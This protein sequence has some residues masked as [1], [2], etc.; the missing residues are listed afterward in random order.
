MARAAKRCLR[1]QARLNVSFR[2]LVRG[3]ENE[4]PIPDRA[5]C[6]VPGRLRPNRLERSEPGGG[7]TGTPPGDAS[8]VGV[9]GVD[10]AECATPQELETAPMAITETGYD[11]Y[12]THC[13]FGM[14][15]RQ[16]AAVWAVSGSCSVQGD[17]Q[18]FSMEM[19][20]HDDQLTLSRDGQ[21][22]SVLQQCA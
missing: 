11:Q 16:G 3:R 21:S 15:E 1:L 5:C 6:L 22:Y 12:E 19:S 7:V 17:E 10:D 13:S 18:T 14:I 2:Q 9:W 20:V 4:I 8:F